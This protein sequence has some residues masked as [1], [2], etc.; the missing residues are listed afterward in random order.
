MTSRL[1]RL[2]PPP[3]GH[4]TSVVIA[5]SQAAGRR[6]VFALSWLQAKND[7]GRSSRELAGLLLKT[8]EV[9]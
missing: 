3:I 9:L 5:M 1:I 4:K 7:P 6:S 8:P 2:S